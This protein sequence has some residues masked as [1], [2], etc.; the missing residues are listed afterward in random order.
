[1]LLAKSI[2]FVADFG[3]KCESH[4]PFPPHLREEKVGCIIGCTR[5]WSVELTT[6]NS[7]LTAHLNATTHNS[8]ITHRSSLITDITDT[9]SNRSQTRRLTDSQRLLPRSHFPLAENGTNREAELTTHNSQHPGTQRHRDDIQRRRYKERHSEFLESRVSSLGTGAWECSCSR[10]QTFIF[11]SHNSQH[12]H[13]FL[14][15]LCDC[16]R[17]A[18]SLLS[19]HHQIISPSQPLLAHRIS[20]GLS[21]QPTT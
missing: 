19:S 13:P 4:F 14:I 3:A 1:M 15:G 9:Y 10:L 17:V 18:S 2:Q 5:L 6:H 12:R 11:T 16:E 7:L 20:L 8:P 21:Q